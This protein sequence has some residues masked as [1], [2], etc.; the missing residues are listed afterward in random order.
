M[1]WYFMVWYG[2]GIVINRVNG[3]LAVSRAFGDIQF[4]DQESVGV[5]IAVPE[6]YSEVITPMTEFAVIATDG[7]WD[8]VSPQAAI[9]LARETLAAPSVDLRDVAQLLVK[10]ALKL[11]SVDNVTVLVISFHL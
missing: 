6:I 8:V 5:V 2:I 3:I 1:V 4:K 10:E 9:N 11:G 7:L